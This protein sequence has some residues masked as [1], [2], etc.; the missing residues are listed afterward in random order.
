MILT[1]DQS[2]S[3]FTFVDAHAGASF[4]IIALLYCIRAYPSR[5][6]HDQSMSGKDPLDALLCVYIEIG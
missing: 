3:T 1:T 5:H 2:A 4:V 6:R